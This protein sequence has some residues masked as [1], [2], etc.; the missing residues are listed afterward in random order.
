MNL[1]S[2][3]KENKLKLIDYFVLPPL[4]MRFGSSYLWFLGEVTCEFENSFYF[5]DA[6]FFLLTLSVL[7]INAESHIVGINKKRRNQ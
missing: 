4:A 1:T 5:T 7:P 6:A 2:A 3:V